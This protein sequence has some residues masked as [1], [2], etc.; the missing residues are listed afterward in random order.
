MRRW[1]SKKRR[2]PDCNKCVRRDMKDCGLYE[3]I[4]GHPLCEE[5]RSEILGRVSE[6]N[7][8]IVQRERGRL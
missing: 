2:E 4:V 3:T 5:K 1:F 7:R 6:N 8:Q